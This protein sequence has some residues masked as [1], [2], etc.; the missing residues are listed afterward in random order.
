MNTITA[1]SFWI[2]GP[3]ASEIR[4]H[5]VET[6]EGNYS[7]VRTLYSGISRGT[8]QLV[9]NARVPPSEYERMRAPHQEGRFPGPVKYGYINVGAVV[10]GPLRGKRVFSL[11]P[12]QT[13]F[14]LPPEA[15]FPIPDG[16][17]AER[18]VLSAN[19][20]TAINGLWDAQIRI[21]DE[22]VVFGA[23]VTGLLVGWLAA[24]VPGCQ[25]TVVDPNP[26]RSR[27][28][29]QLGLRLVA[30]E[31]IAAEYD[32]LINV[33]GS[34]QALAAAI[35]RA[36]FEATIVEMSWYGDTKSSV[37]LG[38][39]FHSRR[40][41]IKSSQV[42]SVANSQRARWSTARRM[43]L[44]LDLLADD[45]LDHLI[46]HTSSFESLPNV[47]RVLTEADQLCHRIEYP[48]A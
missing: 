7:L 48:I 4:E 44:A 33:S 15:L 16:V 23:G 10:A 31:D 28:A 45:R 37:A 43:S 5:A 36:R 19:L 47:M 40:L 12:H 11:F 26:S 25:V 20:E 35:E 42:G 41:T 29:Q 14:Y 17:P 6:P 22:V 46:T 24:R 34:D 21:G 30:P 2:T 18:A 39:A 8:E 13:L 1:Q 27:V 9:F 38:T 32:V 3:G